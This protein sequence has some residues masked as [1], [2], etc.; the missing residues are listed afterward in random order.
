MGIFNFGAKHPMEDRI[1]K[2]CREHGVK[3][4][5]DFLD[6]TDD[7]DEEL[8]DWLTGPEGNI[9]KKNKLVRRCIETAQ[10]EG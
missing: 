8:F 3:D 5:E 10:R 4:Y 2:F 7:H 1:V 6:K 9:M